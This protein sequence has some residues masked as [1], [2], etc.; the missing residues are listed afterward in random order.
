[1]P[2]AQA[3]SLELRFP[4]LG[5]IRRRVQERVASAVNYPA[6]WAV[7]VRLDDPLDRR[8]RGGSRPGLTKFVADDMGTTIADI[9][10][11]GVSSAASGALCSARGRSSRWGS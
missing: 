6:P 5:V 9:A 1:M 7:N 11:I 2:L 8:L 4:A 3:N 10:S